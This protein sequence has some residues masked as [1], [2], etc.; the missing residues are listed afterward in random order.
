[1]KQDRIEVSLGPG[2]T[3]SDLAVVR[4]LPGRR[5]HGRRKI[6]IAPDPDEALRMLEGSFGPERLEVSAEHAGSAA[7]T[8]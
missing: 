4:A 2:F 7:P 1:L 3:D 6:W 8:T 5:W